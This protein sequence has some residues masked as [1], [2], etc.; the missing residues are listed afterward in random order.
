MG[1]S[2]QELR[3]AIASIAGVAPG[4]ERADV[5]GVPRPRQSAVETTDAGGAAT[6]I[7]GRPPAGSHWLVDRGAFVVQGPALGT[8]LWTVFT[9]AVQDDLIEDFA[10]IA[11]GAVLATVRAV[12]EWNP[13]IWVPSSTPWIVSVSGASAA[14]QARVRTVQR[15]IR[16]P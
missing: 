14:V 6:L 2:E 4:Q 12:G 11:V 9:T 3:D 16:N 10:S 13:P 15:E 5:R 7:L 1:M 8:I